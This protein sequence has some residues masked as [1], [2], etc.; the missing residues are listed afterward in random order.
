MWGFPG[1]FPYFSFFASDSNR[2]H[3]LRI[4]RIDT[5][6]VD[7]GVLSEHT[8]GEGNGLNQLKFVSGVK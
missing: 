6:I 1:G 4:T 8:S 2:F 5:N 7:I 3:Y